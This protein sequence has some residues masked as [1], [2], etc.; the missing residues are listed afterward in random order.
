MKRN[1]IIK[2][3]SFVAVAILLL[4]MFALPIS[5]AETTS[6]V[7]QVSFINP[8]FKISDLLQFIFWF[9]EIS[10]LAIG[11]IAGLIN[12]WIGV[13]KD[14][15]NKKNNGWIIIG[16]TILVVIG[17]GAIVGMIFVFV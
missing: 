17:I 9:G 14:E 12:I 4:T 5:A 2:V 15:P 16:A 7:P 3:L 10:I 11:V 1:K 8:D 13:Q 6:N